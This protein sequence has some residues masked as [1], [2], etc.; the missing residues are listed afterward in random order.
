M[1]VCLTAS[2][3]E[4]NIYQHT[5]PFSFSLCAFSRSTCRWSLACANQ[6]EFRVAHVRL[7][8]IFFFR[9]LAH[10]IGATFFFPIPSVYTQKNNKKTNTTPKKKMLTDLTDKNKDHQLSK[11]EFRQLVTL[12]EFHKFLHRLGLS[13]ATKVERFN[14]N[15]IYAFLM[16]DGAPISA[17]FLLPTRVVLACYIYLS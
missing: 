16:G 9:Y 6:A 5:S 4:Y 13:P 2:T 12:P 17:F 10:F 8:D 7:N 1:Y 14:S 3:C 11:L 15:S